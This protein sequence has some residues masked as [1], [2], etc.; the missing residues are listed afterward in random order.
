MS[1]DECYSC[2]EAFHKLDDYIGRA[3]TDEEVAMIEQ[4]LEGCVG[5]AGEYRFESS[6]I[7]GIRE[8]LKKIDLPPDLMKRISAR[9]R[10]EVDED[11]NQ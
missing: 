1:K 9:I 4:H 11:A 7:E 6:L 10:A 2:E 3:L 5:C 8:K